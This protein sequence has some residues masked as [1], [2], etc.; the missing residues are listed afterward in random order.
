MSG[1]EGCLLSRV[2]LYYVSNVKLLTLVVM[3]YSLAE[4]LTLGLINYYS[5][6]DF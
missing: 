2:P 3:I 6:Q 4:G 5:S 1:T